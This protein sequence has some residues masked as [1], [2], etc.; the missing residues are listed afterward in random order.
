MKSFFRTNYSNALFST[1]RRLLKNALS[2]LA[3]FE[4]SGLNLLSAFAEA[5]EKNTF[6]E[7][8]NLTLAFKY[9][10]KKDS[11]TQGLLSEFDQDLGKDVL[12]ISGKTGKVI[13]EVGFN[14]LRIG[15]QLVKGEF[16][17]VVKLIA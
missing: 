8:Y 2:G 13:A 3:V 12:Y 4:A 7:A 10:R 1:R 9:S 17:G 6:P 15:K 5:Q 11:Y 16:A 14:V